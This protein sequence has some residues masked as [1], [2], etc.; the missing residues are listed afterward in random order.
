MKKDSMKIFLVLNFLLL[1]AQILGMEPNP[2]K[3][4][5]GAN[6]KHKQDVPLAPEFKD[7]EERDSFWDVEIP[8][9]SLV[10]SEVKLERF[11]TSDLK[12]CPRSAIA[13]AEQ[14]KNNPDGW[15]Y[16]SDEANEIIKAL[17]DEK[18]EPKDQ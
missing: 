10:F 9:P 2:S 17:E 18:P 14:M 8:D 12:P 13:I 6:K 16:D 4:T 1:S 3:M 15:P 5:Q 11:K 7:D